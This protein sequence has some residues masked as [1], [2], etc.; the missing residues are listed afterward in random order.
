MSNLSAP[1]LHNEEA[2]YDF[3]ESILWQDGP[4]CPHCGCM[5]RITKVKANPE[6]RIRV[7]KVGTVFE[8]SKVK[9]NLWL[10][11]V[12]LM[13][14]SKKGI[15]AHQL[16]RTLD[17]T[18][19]TNWFMCHRIHEA[20]RSGDLAPFGS[21]GGVVEIDETFI[22]HDHNIKPRG[23]K[24]GRGVAHRFKVLSLV[25]RSTGRARSVVVDD[26]KT[27][28]LVPIL[29]ENI[30]AEARVMTDEARHYSRLR[31]DFAE[32]GSV[33]HR[34]GEYVNRENPEIHTNTIEGCFSIFKRGMKGIYQHC[35]KK[36]LH[37]YM[38]EY[39]LRY[40]NRS[41]NGIEDQERARLALKGITGKRLTCGGAGA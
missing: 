30:V 38:A 16:H 19:K 8:A 4:V 12:V 41:A 33:R 40:S 17:V 14:S 21:N 28:T 7:V 3:L 15:S 20:M 1:D 31:N 27:K 29:R 39:D 13:T 25:D 11:A 18:Y 26:L 36:H 34:M 10:Q 23:Q 32:Y 5:G 6:K 24:K 22:G 2:A 35:A 37:R 9:L